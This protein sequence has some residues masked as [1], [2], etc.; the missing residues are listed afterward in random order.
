MILS[1]GTHLGPY[2]IV[3][4][5]G[6]GGMGEVYRARDPRLNRFVAIKIVLSGAR[7]TAERREQFNR[8]AQAV[9]ALVHPNVCR[10]YDV[11]NDHDVD[12]LVM[13]YL[14]GETLASR[15]E[16]GPLPIEDAVRIAGEIAAAL[17]H[18]HQHGL[19]HRDLKP[20]NVMLTAD[21]AKLLDFGLAKRLSGPDPANGATTSTLIGVGVIAGTLQYMAP[22]QIDGQPV[23]E[24]CDIFAFG[25][26][27]YEMLAGRPAFAGDTAS[28]T[29]AAI[30]IGQPA[31]LRT[32]LPDVPPALVNVVA[33]CLAKKPSER[34]SS[35]AEMAEA[36]KTPAVATFA[37]F[38]TGTFEPPSARSI[39]AAVA[40][41]AL[42]AVVAVAL[43]SSFRRGR[44]ASPERAATA[45]TR[46]SIA[47]L[48]FRN[49]S[50][51]PDAAWLSTAFAEM[52]TTD[53]TAGE[54]IR[55]IAGENIARMKLEL[56]LIDTDS[57]A[58][59]TL[60]RIKRNL[61]TELIV[62]GSYV[63]LGQPQARQVRL[64]LRVQETQAGETVASVSETGAEEDLLGLVSRVGS[65]VRRDLGMTAMSAAE[66][67]GL[68][69]SVPSSTEAIRLY[70]EGIEKFRLGDAVESRDLLTK[71]VAADPSNAMAR[72]A[73]AGA[74]SALGYD[75]KARDE[76]KR[77]AD[78]SDSLPREQRLAVQARYRALAGDAKQAID[79]YE[80]LW[81]SFPD[82]L[83][84]GLD[85]IGFQVSGGRGKEALA[86]AALLRQLP[87]PSGDDPRV[88]IVES[89][90]HGLLGNFAQQHASAIAAVQKGSER[91]AALLVADA[92][93]SDC[94]AL[95]RMGRFDEARAACAQSQRMAHD[96]G[97]RSME[98][99]AV[100]MEGN[101]SYN[102][103]DLPKAKQAYE[104]AL[105]IFR[106]TGRK[107]AIAGTL[108]NVANV[109]ND[110]GNLESATRA[111]EESLAIAR[112]LGRKREMATA[113]N[114]LGNVMAKQGDLRGAVERQQQTLAVYREMGDRGGM[115]T[116]LQDIAG[117]LHE[118]GALA[119]AHTRVDEAVRL[120]RE[121]GQKFSEAGALNELCAVLA[122]EGDLAA[123]IKAC[124]E[125]VAISRASGFKGRLANGLQQLALVAIEQRQAAT[126]E[127]HARE[128]FDLMRDQSSAVQAA[129]YDMLAQ[130]YLAAGKVAEA[131]DTVTQ[132]QALPVP[133][134]LVR[135]PL[136]VTVARAQE[137]TS[138]AESIRK[139]RGIIVEGTR[140]GAVRTVF[141]ARLALA[142]MQARAGDRAAARA[143]LT[144]L[145]KDST[146]RGFVLLARKTRAA[147]DQLA[148]GPW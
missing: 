52:L 4:P 41:I 58:R 110:R 24:R 11:G 26:I 9:A 139:L 16:R 91:G 78:L 17:A 142:S 23:D 19:V 1:T 21:G 126:A 97:D 85:L 79:A 59:D 147:I 107:F 115:V 104:N 131:R 124:E 31:P 28:S 39:W 111:Y 77:A 8:E 40:A 123:A 137:S 119:D 138:R 135:L 70:A 143:Q 114:N 132:A 18:T 36:L 103:H 80:Q 144:S 117:N 128:A 112:E 122:D 15:M 38:S 95:W 54:Q 61:G 133:S 129:G 109:D 2:E 14:E 57:Y 130:A 99:L 10:I 27:L 68:R 76:A 96:A 47:V 98:A 34:W 48:G 121:T 3:E 140:H 25:A 148:A 105:A 65:R 75:G 102:Q 92:H 87:R 73:L 94:Q 22:E 49:L 60:A 6:H 46:R 82:N 89:R 30:L 50:G 136:E 83:D 66:S 56:K 63:V 20:G 74:W 45:P 35:A 43:A 86:T 29:M 64:D 55:A 7:V 100:V 42:I 125:S 51:R 134:L 88:D 44:G 69:A 84:Y 5:L 108:I 146:A 120:G 81:H 67:A 116:V 37:T 118:Q 101:V 32:V 113:L 71:A 141:D 145:E 90:A 106:E 33:K 62:V 53:L 72:S 13:E 93:R 12:Y 127:Q